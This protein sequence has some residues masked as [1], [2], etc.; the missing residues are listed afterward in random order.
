[1]LELHQA[2][3][4]K[5]LVAYTKPR[6]EKVA[7]ENLERQG[8][9][10]YLPL[11]KKFKNTETG[12]VPFFEPLF[13]RYILFRPSKTEQSIE[14]VRNTKGISHVVRF[15]YEPGLL[16]QVIVDTIRSLEASQNLATPEEMHN[17]KIGQKVR[18]N[19]VTLSNL[20]GLVQKVSKKR[21]EVLLEILGRQIV[22]KI[23]QHL[24]EKN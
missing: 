3:E 17:L 10:V 22:L 11:Y 2:L 9:E 5:W 1:M 20:E 14:T 16:G 15:G 12:A 18:I 6:L 21:V 19:Y 4:D 24:V 8:F 7:L 13:P 23:D